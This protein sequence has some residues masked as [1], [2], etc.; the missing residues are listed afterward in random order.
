M[1]IAK[2]AAK[3]ERVSELTKEFKLMSVLCEKFGMTVAVMQKYRYLEATKKHG[4]QKVI[5][6]A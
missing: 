5:R 3:Y 2:L 6:V 1:I 4:V